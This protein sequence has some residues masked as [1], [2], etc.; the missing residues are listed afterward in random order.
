LHVVGDASVHAAGAVLW[1]MSETNAE[2]RIE[3]RGLRISQDP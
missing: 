3:A 1:M 2:T